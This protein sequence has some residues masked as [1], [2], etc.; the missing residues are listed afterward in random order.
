MAYFTLDI[1]IPPRR[2]ESE[3]SKIAGEEPFELLIHRQPL[4][5]PARPAD[6]DT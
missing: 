6:E 3:R 1:T 2:G 5:R 4:T